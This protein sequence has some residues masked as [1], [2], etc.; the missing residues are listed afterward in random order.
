MKT[1]ATSNK[2]KKIRKTSTSNQPA[3][4]DA[5]KYRAYPTDEQYEQIAK[6]IGSA[7]YYWNLTHDIV[8]ITYEEYGYSI[9]PTPAEAKKWDECSWLADIDSLA[10]TNT[11]ANYQQAWKNHKQNPK[12]Y[13][14]PT[15]K[16]RKGLEGSYQTNNQP[17]W[18]NE[19][20]E[21][22]TPGSIRIRDSKIYLPKVGWV[23]I[24]E[25]YKIPKNAII[26]NVTVS[27][28]CAGRVY[29]SIGYWNPE[30]D[31]IMRNAGLD[32]TKDTLT[33][34]ALDYSNPKLFIDQGGHSPADVHYYKQSE[35]QL[36]RLQRKLARRSPGSCNYRKLNTRI[37]RLHRKIANQRRDLL[38]KLSHALALSCDV[39]V[40]ESLDLRAL[41]KRKRGGKYSFG[42]SVSDNAWG[43][44]LTFLEYKLA[45]NHGQLVRVGK[46][47]PSSKKCHHCGALKD[48][49]SLSDRVW[50]CPECGA[51]HDRDVNAAWN[52]LFEGVRMLRA[53]EVAGVGVSPDVVYRA[54]GMPV[55]AESGERVSSLPGVFQDF[56]VVPVEGCET[57]AEVLKYCSCDTGLPKGCSDLREAGIKEAALAGKLAVAAEASS[58]AL[59]RA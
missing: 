32:T 15:R 59:V 23:K 5:A 36:A 37:A 47:Y 58:S 38:H 48:D 19:K 35:K 44:F 8:L 3:A 42:K 51:V 54:G 24:H 52:I 33:I 30:L 2:K 21:Y 45:R 17:K 20:K 1:L 40:V 4:N 7:R 18:D 57:I 26:K 46:Y 11:W 12:H 53:G 39:V 50:E 56:G 25:H 10:L 14:R 27:R 22:T 6:T 9:T 13:G 31:E 34:E 43:M 41:S 28:D 29:I 16:K 55:A 49:L